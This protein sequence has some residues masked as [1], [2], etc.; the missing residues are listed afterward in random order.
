MRRLKE[1]LE[2]SYKETQT[3]AKKGDH[4]GVARNVTK[5]LIGFTDLLIKPAKGL[6]VLKAAPAQLKMLIPVS[7]A[8][9]I[10]VKVIQGVA[11]KYGLEIGIRSTDPL[12]AAVRKVGTK[13][14]IVNKPMT[15]KEKSTLGL[16]YDAKAK[17]IILSDLDV[18]HIIKDG[19]LLNHRESLPYL[20]EIN[21]ALKQHGLQPPIQH[22]SHITA[23]KLLGGKLTLKEYG[24]IGSPG[25]VT[26]Y[27]G[28]GTKQLSALQVDRVYSKYGYGSHGEW[29]NPA[30]LVEE[31]FW[32]S[33]SDFHF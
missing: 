6:T 29:G 15:I 9:K 27:N 10:E 8:S 18:S 12:T 28:K 14:R 25:P 20:S 21:R 24:G 22:P 4:R 2:Q 23:T 19:K 1:G 7:G 3:L 33:V 26:V 11:E 32:T 5:T 30:N 17:K 13:F 16:L 31:H